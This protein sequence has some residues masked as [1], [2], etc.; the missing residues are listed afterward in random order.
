M[1]LK[2]GV[3]FLPAFRCVMTTFWLRRR[4]CRYH[5]IM[6]SHW[7]SEICNTR[8]WF[9]RNRVKCELRVPILLKSLESLY[10]QNVTTNALI[11]K[12]A[13]V[14]IARLTPDR[15]AS[16][17]GKNV[18]EPELDSRGRRLIGYDHLLSV[19]NSQMILWAFWATPSFYEM[20]QCDVIKRFN[21]RNLPHIEIACI[22]LPEYREI[23]QNDT[24]NF[25]HP[26]VAG[27]SAVSLTLDAGKWAVHIEHRANLALRS[28]FLI[29]C[30]CCLLKQTW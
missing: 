29:L 26:F 8:L 22:Q 28:I 7:I 4:C 2:F 10:I 15:V 19:S 6:N 21:Y 23:Q 18:I 24:S 16:W 11:E 9:H 27:Y 3:C 1:Q 13:F 17:R 12:T 14:L 30:V 25:K 5:M 20:I